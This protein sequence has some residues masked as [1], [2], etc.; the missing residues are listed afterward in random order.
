MPT[1]LNL[2]QDER[3]RNAIR[4]TQLVHRL[5]RFALDEIEPGSAK[6][7]DPGKPT[8]MT[9]EQVAAAI[10]LLR[11]TLPDLLSTTIK[12]DGDNGAITVNLVKFAGTIPSE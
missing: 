5:E 3:T 4:T 7:G 12:G 10:A 11:K 2:K 6:G 8:K 1:R 9:K